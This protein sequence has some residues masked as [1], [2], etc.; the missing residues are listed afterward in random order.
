MESLPFNKISPKAYILAADGQFASFNQKD[1]QVWSICLDATNKHLFHLETTYGLRARSM[2]LIP[3]FIYQNQ[4]VTNETDF[5]QSPSI[6]HYTPSMIQIIFDLKNGL[7]IKFTSFMPEPELLLGEVEIDSQSDMSTEL[8]FD[9]AGILVPMGEGKSMRPEKEGNN[10]I[11]VGQSSNLYP[12]IFMTGGPNAI[13]D[14]Y[15]SLTK[16]LQFSPHQSHHLSWALVTKVSI[17]ASYKIARQAV[18]SAWQGEAQKQVMKTAGQTIFIQTGD[19]DWDHAFFL[20]QT[21]A[22]AHQVASFSESTD[23]LII[24]WRHPDYHFDARYNLGETGHL[25]NLEIVQLAQ[26]MLPAQADIFM[27]L[28]ER[29]LDRF[30][31]SDYRPVQMPFDMKTCQLK[32]C[33]LLSKLC[34]EIF[35]MTNDENFLKRV[36]PK[37][38]HLIDLCRL[39][40]EDHLIDNFPVWES[41]EQLQLDTGL[42][43][44]DMWS[45]Q[46]RGLDIES[47]ESPALAAMFYQEATALSK[48]AQLLGD[49]AAFNR[50]LSLKNKLHT[51]LQNFWQPDHSC[52]TYLDRQSHKC[53]HGEPIFEGFIQESIDLSK[54]FDEP[55]RLHIQLISQDD[56]TRACTIHLNG[57]NAEGKNIIEK[58]RVQNLRWVM[59]KANVTTRNL[60]TN[61]QTITFEGMGLKDRCLVETIDLSQCDISCLL[62]IGLGC[63]K[64]EQLSGL[65]KSLLHSEIPL[66]H[67]LPETW[68]CLSEL[69]QKLPLR[70]NVMWNTLIIEG[71]VREGFQKEAMRIF[72]AL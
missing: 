8:T 27:D 22:K 63:F 34:L 48:I 15:P 5:A 6:K 25:T 19:P 30:V 67:G 33:P 26:V 12:L 16:S 1:D 17:S 20:T 56:S 57:E 35:E 68:H 36:F 7:H 51:K 9:L 54:R 52:F 14:P 2:R 21:I 40:N 28:I 45:E 71:F 3:Y 32:A 37:L 65:I 58:I 55:Q 38:T 60:Y 41:P 46:S 11:L 4:A 29:T 10:H 62:P 53:S 24:S 31:E 43:S 72:N 50:Y 13:S 66:E 69:P 23:P 47:V 44:F 42:F 64:P 39:P 49:D 61:L 18:A 70:V 59:G